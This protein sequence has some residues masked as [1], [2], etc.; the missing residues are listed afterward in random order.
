MFVSDRLIYIQMQKTASTHI[1]RVLAEVVGGEQHQ[2]HIRLRGDRDGRLVVVSVRSPWD[3][4]V[5]LW[6]YGCRGGGGRSGVRERLTEPPPG[7]GEIAGA[8]WK[9][10][11]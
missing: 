11:R 7:Y 8:A 3:W 6:A 5:S 4:Y 2:Q 9:S 10:M 1:A